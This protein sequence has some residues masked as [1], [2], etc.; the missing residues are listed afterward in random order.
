MTTRT[1]ALLLGVIFLLVG[2]M[3]FIPP[4]V[5]APDY[6]AGTDEMTVIGG[7]GYLLGLF[8]VNW[9]HNVI[10]LAFGAWGVLAWKSL[11]GGP[12]LYLKVTAVIYGL[13]VIMGLIPVLQ[14][15]FGLAPLWGH[16]LWLH[17]LIAFTA[18]YYAWVH[19]D[20]P[21]KGER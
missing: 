8:P 14:A 3:G 16:D 10:H 19:K 5:T 1:F 4:F 21:V 2:V 17:F 6:T 18:G 15:T 11:A 7:Y 12:R 20:P 9:V 13:L